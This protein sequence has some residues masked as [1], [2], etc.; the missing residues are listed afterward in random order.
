M[1]NRVA[2]R[3]AATLALSY[4]FVA[5]ALGQSSQQAP[6]ASQ[7]SPV[8]TLRARSNL[9]LVPALV[10]DNQGETVFSLTA[11]DFRLTDNGSPQLLRLESDMDSQPLALVVIVQT[12]G[13]GAFHLQDYRDLGSVLDAV[14]GNVLQQPGPADNLIAMRV[15]KRER[16]QASPD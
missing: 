14:I 13:L 11:D 8:P 15:G 7:S 1:T 4:V 10:K 2:L 3:F 16:Q 9:V 5:A 6:Q 12:G